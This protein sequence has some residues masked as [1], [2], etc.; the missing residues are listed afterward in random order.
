MKKIYRYLLVGTAFMLTYTSCNFLD[1]DPQGTLDGDLA[2][3]QVEALVT[4]AYSALGND[5]YLKQNRQM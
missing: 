2:E 5:H 3:N 1:H 4:S